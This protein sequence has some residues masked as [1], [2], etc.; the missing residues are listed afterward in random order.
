M[1]LFNV[2]PW[3]GVVPYRPFRPLGPMP[4]RPFRHLSLYDFK[5]LF[6]P[7]MKALSL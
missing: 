5:R 6:G 3:G 1:T 4:F 7:K 2:I